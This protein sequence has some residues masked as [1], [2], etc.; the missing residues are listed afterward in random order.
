[1]FA[2]VD[3]FAF[4]ILKDFD[5]DGGKLLFLQ[6]KFGVKIDAFENHSVCIFNRSSFFDCL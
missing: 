2:L 1:M 4:S 6:I 5:K 3:P